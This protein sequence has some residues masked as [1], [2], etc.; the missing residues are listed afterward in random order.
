MRYACLAS[1]HRRRPVFAH[2]ELMCSVA[3]RCAADRKSVDVE[4]AAHIHRVLSALND[5]EFARRQV[6]I[7]LFINLFLSLIF[8]DDFFCG[9]GGGG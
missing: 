3:L 9:G 1:Q 7:Y 4:T 8:G 2:E 5:R 6:F